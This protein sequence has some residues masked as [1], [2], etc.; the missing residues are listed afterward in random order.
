MAQSESFNAEVA[1]VNESLAQW[2]TAAVAQLF[3]LKPAQG[4]A[5]AQ[6]PAD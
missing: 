5:Q 6:N 3:G 4:F 2:P 1:Q